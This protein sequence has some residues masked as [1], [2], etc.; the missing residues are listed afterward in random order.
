M[1]GQQQRWAIRKEVPQIANPQIC[2]FT[3]FV[4][5]ETFQV[6]QFANLR[7]ADPIS[8][9]DLRICNLRTKYFADLILPQ[10]RQFLIF[11]LEIYTENV[12]K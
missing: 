9:C 7:F 2:G 10:I 6:W 5:I 3:K 8:V 12:L 11:S 1:L 4:I